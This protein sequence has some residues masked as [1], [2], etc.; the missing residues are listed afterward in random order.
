MIT[1]NIHELYVVAALQVILGVASLL[2]WRRY[3]SP[4]RDI[5]GPV[6]ASLSRLWHVKH[7]LSGDH[8]TQSVALHNKH[9][10]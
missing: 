7:I 2:V 9:G 4:L 6:P 5:P 3:L 10:E 1:L 8:N